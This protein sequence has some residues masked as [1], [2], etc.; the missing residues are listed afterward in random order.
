MARGWMKEIFRTVA[1]NPVDV[2]LVESFKRIASRGKITI[3][4]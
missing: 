2:D 1:G 4:L 3:R